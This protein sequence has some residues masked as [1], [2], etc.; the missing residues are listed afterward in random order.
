MAQGVAGCVERFRN[1]G[2]IIGIITAAVPYEVSFTDNQNEAIP[3]YIAAHRQGPRH[4]QDSIPSDIAAQTKVTIYVDN[5]RTRKGACI[6]NAGSWSS[7]NWLRNVAFKRR[8]QG[9]Q[10][11]DGLKVC[12]Q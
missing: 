2:A 11:R 4:N 3:P 8:H 7:N 12:R 1:Y 9:L 5:L 6:R 10:G